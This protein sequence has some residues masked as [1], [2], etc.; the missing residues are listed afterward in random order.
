LKTRAQIGSGRIARGIQ[1]F[2]A[3]FQLS[4]Y[5]N[6][7]LG[8]SQRIQGAGI[9]RA[10]VAA[11]EDLLGLGFRLAGAIN[12]YFCRT[13]GCFREDRNF[14]WQH[15]RKTPRYRETVRN[16]RVAVGDLA[17]TQFGDE[18]GVSWENAEIAIAAWNFHLLGHVFDNLAFGGHDL[19][20]ESV[21]HLHSRP[22][23]LK[24]PS[25]LHGF[26]TA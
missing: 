5:F 22:Q 2:L 13:L 21:C 25:H 3:L 4:G 7:I 1:Y 19:E 14:I 16:I 12:I 6:P 20:L 8:A 17:D 24:P 9:I 11:L 23:G 26:G 18:G 10:W 15:F